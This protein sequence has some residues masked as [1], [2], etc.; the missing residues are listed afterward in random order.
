MVDSNTITVG[1]FAEAHPNTS[2]TVFITLSH[3][4]VLA[5]LSGERL[6]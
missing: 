3:A 2:G 4:D 1:V 6:Q 5:V